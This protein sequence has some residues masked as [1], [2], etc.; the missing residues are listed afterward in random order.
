MHRSI[1]H[2]RR[3]EFCLGI[4]E[5]EPH[6]SMKFV[7]FPETQVRYRSVV[8]KS[9]LKVV[10]FQ[11]PMG[12]YM[13]REVASRSIQ[14]R[15]HC[16]SITPFEQLNA[17]TRVSTKSQACRRKYRSAEQEFALQDARLVSSADGSKRTRNISGHGRRC[18][19]QL[20]SMSQ[21]TRSSVVHWQILRTHV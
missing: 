14:A 1:A 17:E 20:S 13:S 12:S 8:L 16:A 4:C 19:V 5:K 11:R 7:Q 10:V 3:S 21:S 15:A 9:E 2:R 6:R 18:R